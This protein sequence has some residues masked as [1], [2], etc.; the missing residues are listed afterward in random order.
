MW[1]LDSYDSD[2]RYVQSVGLLMYILLPYLDMLVL[3]LKLWYF[4]SDPI[5]LYQTGHLLYNHQIQQTEHTWSQNHNC[6]IVTCILRVRLNLKIGATMVVIWIYQQSFS[7][8]VAVSLLVEET[9]VS[10]EN[11]QQA[12]SH[13]QTLSHNVVSSTPCYE[14]DSNSQHSWW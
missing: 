1:L 3:L 9:G 7:Y 6:L 13:W 2:F 4:C 10:G 5:S 8:I 12:A 11:H 14:W